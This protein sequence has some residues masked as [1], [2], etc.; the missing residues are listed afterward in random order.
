MSDL[1][2][3]FDPVCPFA[4]ITSRWVTEVQQLRS[5]DVTWRFISLAMINEHRVGTEEW[6]TPEYRAGHLAGHRA[7]RVADQ[8][9]LT[10]DNATVAAYYTAL[11][12][13]V[14]RD[15]R[16]DDFRADTL[17]LIAAAA[18]AAGAD[19]SVVAHADDES[20]DAHLRAE[21]DLA[22]SRTGKD[23]GTP[24][25]T[26]HPGAEN[27]S[28]FFGPVISKTPRGDDALR[29]WDA[30][31]VLATTSGLAELK[32]SNRAKLDFT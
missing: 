7:L 20:H 25:L 22:F 14:H 31:E 27:E 18:A 24:I 29:L 9:R 2:F 12:N 28:S 11:G 10:A 26:F 17:G 8:I 4:W 16:R 15:G 23:V 1:E 30:V 6:Y 32:R 3:F 21:T 13:A 5:Y 19:P